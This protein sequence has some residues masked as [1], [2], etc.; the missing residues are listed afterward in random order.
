M[1]SGARSN[2]KTRGPAPAPS[3]ACRPAGWVGL[4]LVTLTVVG[5][6]GGGERKASSPTP[7]AETVAT[8][9][10]AS[11]A[12]V[13]ATPIPPTVAPSP[14]PSATAVT[15]ASQPPPTIRPAEP[16]LP[17]AAPPAVDP[18][19]LTV[20]ARNLSF[21]PAALTIQAHAVVTLIM[22]NE[23]SSVPHDLGVNVVGG[24][25]TETCPGPCTSSFVFAAHEAGSYH[26]FCSL[27]PEM[28]GDL[29]VTP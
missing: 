26:F 7:G 17:T 9:V 25:R 29:R 19:T 13:A 11:V 21:S 12:T 27:H 16:V 5:C 4:L 20:V 22:K 14:E 8:P 2:G 10:V 18:I 24:G 6:S 1:R 3:R 15:V 28:V 23:D